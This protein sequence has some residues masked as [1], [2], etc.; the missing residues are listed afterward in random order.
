M[1]GRISGEGKDS[2]LKRYMLSSTMYNSQDM[3]ATLNVHQ[4]MNDKGD[5]MYMCVYIYTHTHMM[6]YYLA[7]K[8]VK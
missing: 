7:I 8:G 4:Q 3:E 2:N 1:P 5:V 6:E